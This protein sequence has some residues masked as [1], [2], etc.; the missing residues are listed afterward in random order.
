M[1]TAAAD[2][3]AA[4]LGNAAA[5]AAIFYF[6]YVQTH[7]HAGIHYPAGAFFQP[8]INRNTFRVKRQY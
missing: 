7:T 4:Q 2:A 3:V 1:Q 5:A 8:Y 6:T